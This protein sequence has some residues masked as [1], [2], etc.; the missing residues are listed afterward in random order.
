MNSASHSRSGMLAIDGPL[1]AASLVRKSSVTSSPSITTRVVQFK[2]LMPTIS[3]NICA[4]GTPYSSAI[5]FF[6]L[7][8]RLHS[9]T[10]R[11]LEYLETASVIMPAGL[12]KLTMNA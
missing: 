3:M 2:W 8:G 10:D 7:I 9:P 1:A 12:V 5:C 11:T 6:V 4:S